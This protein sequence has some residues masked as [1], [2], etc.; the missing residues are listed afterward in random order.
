MRAAVGLSVCIHS[1]LCFSQP[2]DRPYVFIARVSLGEKFATL[3]HAVV[4]S[5]VSCVVNPLQTLFT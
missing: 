1:C 5:G 3:S 2:S 4:G